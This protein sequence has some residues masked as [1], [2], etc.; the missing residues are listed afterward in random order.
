MGLP[1]LPKRTFR[2]RIYAR[3]QARTFKDATPVHPPARAWLRDFSG[4]P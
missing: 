2:V 4:S 3:S 1:S